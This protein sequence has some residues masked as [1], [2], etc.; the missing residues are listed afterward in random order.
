MHNR[1]Y[2]SICYAS[3]GIYIYKNLCSTLKIIFKT[4]N[5]Y[6]TAS[7]LKKKI[8]LFIMCFTA[9]MLRTKNKDL[10]TSSR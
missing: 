7:A 1:L 4:C 10:T 9:A 5:C 6:L 3:Y 2:F 8:Y